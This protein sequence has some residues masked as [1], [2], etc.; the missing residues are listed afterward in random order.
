MKKN[1]NRLTL[2]F[3]IIIV[4]FYVN[5]FAKLEGHKTLTKD[6][7]S[8]NKLSVDTAFINLLNKKAY[9]FRKAMPDSTKA[10]AEEALL[11]SN[12]IAYS[13]GKGTAYINLGLAHLMSFSENDSAEVCMNAG[14]KIF[15]NIDDKN[16]MGFACW[17][18]GFGY[19]F[20]GNMK[21]SEEYLLKSLEYYTS[22]SNKRGM[23]NAVSS[24][25]FVNQQYKKYDISLEFIQ[26][27]IEYAKDLEDT[28]LI[29]NAYNNLGNI[30]KNKALF[31]Q[32]MDC[33]FKA[34]E[35]WESKKDS[36]GM[37]YAYSGI[38]SM[39]YYQ[40]NFDKALEYYSSV[41]IF[42]GNKEYYELS[43]AYNNIALVNNALGKHD[44]ALKYL[45]KSFNL[46]IFM[47][48][49]PGITNNYFDMAETFYLM[50]II[51]SALIYIDRSI[52]MVSATNI[53]SVPAASY[54]LKG[55]ILLSANKS[56]DAL[57]NI[58]LGYK[59][60]KKSE[61][62]YTISEAS[63]VLREIYAS[64][65]RFDLAYKYLLE[66][67]QMQD[68]IQKEENVKKLT[69][70][71][72]QYEFDKK[73]RTLELE[74][75]QEQNRH[76]KEMKQQRAYLLIIIV[77]ALLIII[78][79][80]FII[81]QKNVSTK[82]K[83]IA[84]EQKILR[85][86]MDPHFIFNSLC[87]IQEFILNNRPKEANAFLSKFSGLMRS[88]LENSRND[89]VLLE[90]EIESLKNYMEI[91]KLRFETD[92]DY[93][94][95]IAPSIDISTYRVPPMMAQPFI[96]N[97][98]EHGLLP[99]KDKGKVEIHYKLNN[100]LITIEINDNGIGRKESSF[101]KTEQQKSRQSLATIVTMERIAYL[102][103]T[104][105]KNSRFEILDINK[106]G[107]TGTYVII[108]IPYKIN[109]S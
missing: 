84:L 56:T 37:A 76:D 83:T 44:V 104:V 86:Q 85:M 12:E 106:N 13:K 23:F 80:I 103:K 65:G 95:N 70:L 45:N 108:K 60:A 41:P 93:S 62:P 71:E 39:Y 49:I 51:D 11:L 15:K 28:S 69:R 53:E 20:K 50:G 107:N 58:L 9:E 17:G 31:Q 64:K 59:L 81:K 63:N 96:E 6:Q 14:Y 7:K 109:L 87:A 97:S 78:S 32:A 43:K 54:L 40:N 57:E 25:S 35:M 38:G 90:N 36:T 4:F 48:Y 61:I 88:I 1:S 101:L 33:Y 102:K 73:K 8:G 21:K 92:L 74:K 27:A 99:K 26:C 72:I 105:N 5:G 46:N 18:L 2:C 10:F 100:G 30:Y 77:I 47:N 16:G 89:F 52:N 55:K 75:E 19:T 98:I 34:L 82:Y 68:N 91:Q 66:F 24:L 3:S 29:A 42:M 67:K 94:I 79:I 22:V